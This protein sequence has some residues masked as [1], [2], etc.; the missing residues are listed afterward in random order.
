MV[1]LHV[2]CEYVIEVQDVRTSSITMPSLVGLGLLVPL[3]SENFDVY[4]YSMLEPNSNAG[5]SVTHERF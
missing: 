1:K 3:G 4:R 5:T 2:G